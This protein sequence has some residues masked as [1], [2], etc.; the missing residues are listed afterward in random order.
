MGKQ[1]QQINATL[2]PDQLLW[3]LFDG[4]HVPGNKL[5]VARWNEIICLYTT[6]SNDPAIREG[7]LSSG[8]P[9]LE[10][11]Q[12]AHSEFF[13]QLLT[14]NSQSPEGRAFNKGVHITGTSVSW[15]DKKTIQEKLVTIIGTIEEITCSTE[16]SHL[17]SSN[18]DNWYEEKIGPKDLYHIVTGCYIDDSDK[19]EISYSDFLEK[20]INSELLER[21][22]ELFQLG[23][24]FAVI[25]YILLNS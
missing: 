23:A 14:I 12:Q 10:S 8:F 7:L 3:K 4:F 24:R 2:S 13:P 22:K 5:S 25:K 6:Y 19:A 1:E 9:Y 21:Y 15:L 11:F 16:R 17:N 20:G 18:N